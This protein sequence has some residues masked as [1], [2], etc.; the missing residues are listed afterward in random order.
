MNGARN[1][2]LPE[3]LCK[4]A[5]QKYAHR[6][7]SIEELVTEMLTELVRDDAIKMDQNEA[8]IVEDRLK[9]LGYV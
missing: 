3:Q 7:G 8:K 9:A 6:F 4:L 1:V 2:A 5:E